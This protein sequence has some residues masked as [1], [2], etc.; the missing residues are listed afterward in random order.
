MGYLVGGHR[1]VCRLLGRGGV[2]DAVAD[3]YMLRHGSCGRCS[4]LS[5]HQG[6]NF[7]E[8]LCLHALL[9]SR[10]QWAQFKHSEAATMASTTPGW[11]RN[12]LCPVPCPFTTLCPQ[13][14]WATAADKQ[15][16]PQS[17]FCSMTALFSDASL[18]CW[19]C[20]RAL[21]HGLLQPSPATPQ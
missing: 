11:A 1:V 13:G 10:E 21:L 3:S 12:A 20:E 19:T 6:G 18:H 8:N 7:P 9:P 14:G 15:L 17:W 16:H 5:L 4:R 2:V